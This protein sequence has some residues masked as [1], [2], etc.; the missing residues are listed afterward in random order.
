MY[1]KGFLAWKHYKRILPVPSVCYDGH[2]A[3]AVGK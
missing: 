2:A 3:Q 1:A